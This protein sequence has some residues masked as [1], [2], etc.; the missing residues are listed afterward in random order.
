MISR[1]V[2]FARLSAALFLLAAYVQADDAVTLPAGVKAVWDEAKAYRETTPTRE[3]ICLNGLWRW[4][5]AQVQSDEVPSTNWGYF[6]VPGNWPGNTDYLQKDS[7]TVFT[8]PAWKDQRIAD[9]TAAWHE[10]TFSVPATWI[11]RRVSID[12]AYLNSDASVVVDGKKAGEIHYPGGELDITAAVRPGTRQTLSLLVIALPL[13]GVL[14]S[15]TD[16]AHAREVKGSVARRGLCGDVYLIGA[17]E[18]PRIGDV[19]IATSV[20][21]KEIRFSPMLEGLAAAGRYTLVARVSKDGRV[22]KEI[23]SAP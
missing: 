10:R 6:K 15:Y 16:S 4:Q 14:L 12:L 22:V 1:L 13:K 19:Q 23:A 2:L 11:G 7:Q 20:R 5:P 9:V 18:G 8:H 17:P 21:K 3:R